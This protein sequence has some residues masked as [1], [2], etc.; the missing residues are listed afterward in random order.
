MFIQIFTRSNKTIGSAGQ[1]AT[2][3]GRIHICGQFRA[4]MP[5]NIT[6]EFIELEGHAHSR[7]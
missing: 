3:R 4:A 7:W 6:L 5:C 2:T 1:I